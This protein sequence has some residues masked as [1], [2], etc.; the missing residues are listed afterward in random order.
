M[1]PVATNPGVSRVLDVGCGDGLLAADLADAGRKRLEHE[2]VIV[3][4]RVPQPARV[5]H[6]QDP[7]LSPLAKMASR[8]AS[9][10]VRPAGAIPP[11]S[12][13]VA[14][15]VQWKSAACQVCAMP[16]RS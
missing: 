15:G 1:L 13:F 9:S 10:V 14:A 4:V 8:T 2:R 5:R 11:P 7:G 3:R 6:Y 12:S 16:P